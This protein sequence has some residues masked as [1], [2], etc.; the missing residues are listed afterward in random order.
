MARKKKNKH[1]VDGVKYLTPEHINK[2]EVFQK[3]EE[4]KKLEL[5]VLSCKSQVMSERRQKLSTELEVVNKELEIVTL[6]KKL[7]T[8][9]HNVRGNG[10]REFIEMLKNEYEIEGQIGFDPETG[11]LK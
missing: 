6:K 3:D 11:E 7:L 2:L 1:I 8:L 5:E 10:Y 9:E 4:L